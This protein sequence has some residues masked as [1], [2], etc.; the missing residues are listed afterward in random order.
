MDISTQRNAP[1]NHRGLG[2][3]RID[4]YGFTNIIVGVE[5]GKP[6]REGGNTRT[7]YKHRWL[8]E[9]LHGPI[10]ND[11]MLK[12]LDGNKQN[13]DPSNWIMVPRGLIKRL[14]KRGFETAPPEIKK[15]ILGVALLECKVASKK[16]EKSRLA[17]INRGVDSDKYP[18]SNLSSSDIPKIRQMLASGS[19]D[20]DVGRVY[21]VAPATIRDV[22]VGKTWRSSL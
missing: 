20:R 15:A 17:A 22:R 19:S 12:C 9:K 16:E 3:E 5:G 4:S 6:K 1:H 14:L 10:P 18:F 11:M 7:V 2:Y 21:D 13:T 8:W